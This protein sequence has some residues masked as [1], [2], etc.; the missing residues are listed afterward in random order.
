MAFHT[1]PPVTS[2]WAR[3]RCI[4]EPTKQGDLYTLAGTPVVW[5]RLP[6]RLPDGGTPQ[7]MSATEDWAFATG[8]VTRSA[9]EPGI[10]LYPA[11]YREALNRST[12]NLIKYIVL[13]ILVITGRQ[14]VQAGV[15]ID[16]SINP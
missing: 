11:T 8:P 5:A 6:G 9:H 10:S 12:N 7:R 1:P 3:Y 13:S 2:Y 15:L 14:L 4:Q 16:R